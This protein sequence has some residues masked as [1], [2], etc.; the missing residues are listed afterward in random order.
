MNE[1]QT[2]AAEI[3]AVYTNGQFE[4]GK[5]ERFAKVVGPAGSFVLSHPDNDFYVVRVDG[6]QMSTHHYKPGS[7]QRVELL[8]EFVARFV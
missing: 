1:L 3:T 5:S 6:R 2:I 4:P 8:Q 7:D